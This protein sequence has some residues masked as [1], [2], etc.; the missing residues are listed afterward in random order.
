MKDFLDALFRAGEETC[1]TAGPYGTLVLP[2]EY[3]HAPSVNF[4]S[5][6]P[7]HTRRADANV[8]AWRNFLIELDGMSIDEQH[9]YIDELEMPWTTCVYSG[10]KSLHFII[11]LE[12]SLPNETEYR[13]LAAHLHSAVEKAD[14]SSKNPSRLSRLPGVV[15][16]DTGKEQRLIKIREPIPLVDF[17]TWLSRYPAPQEFTP[18]N[19]KW[20]SVEPIYESTKRLLTFGPGGEDGGR[21]SRV[22]KA[23]ANLCAAGW[24]VDQIV[25]GLLRYVDRNYDLTPEKLRPIVDDICEWKVRQ[26]QLRAE[27]QR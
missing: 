16:P 7:L 13:K 27:N 19:G 1:F 5:I 2:C 8:T 26:D 22:F 12:E 21:Y 6:N 15:R 23:T 9:H 18:R 3:R 10:G 4:F 14:H 24:T 25:E 17:Q 20:R 11:A